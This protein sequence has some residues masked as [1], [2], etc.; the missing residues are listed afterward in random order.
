MNKEVFKAFEE[1]VNRN[2]KTVVAHSNDTRR[3]LRI[4]EQKVHHLEKALLKRDEEI[5][6]LKM[7]LSKVQQKLWQ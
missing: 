7:Q 5:N 4:Q 1:V 2:L 3:M 6:N